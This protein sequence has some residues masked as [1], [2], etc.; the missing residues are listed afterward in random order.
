[1]TIAVSIAAM[2]PAMN[3][4]PLGSRASTIFAEYPAEVWPKYAPS[5]TPKIS[6]RMPTPPTSRPGLAAAAA[7]GCA[8]AITDMATSRVRLT[9]PSETASATVTSSESRHRMTT[10]TANSAAAHSTTGI[11]V[12]APIVVP[13]P[14][15]QTTKLAASSANSTGMTVALPGRPR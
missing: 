7:T 6:S 11:P 2:F 4:D 3:C 15:R 9:N 8:N 1:M 13:T 5:A 10:F 14:T 12:A